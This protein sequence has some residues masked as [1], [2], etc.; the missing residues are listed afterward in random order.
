MPKNHQLPES[1]LSN[2]HAIW[3][4]IIQLLKM[5][6]P[7]FTRSVFGA[8]PPNCGFLVFNISA[9]WHSA[10]NKEFYSSN[11]Y[12]DISPAPNVQKTGW[13]GAPKFQERGLSQSGLL[14]CSGFESAEQFTER[15]QP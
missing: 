13:P 8:N 3:C 2:Y 1:S 14:I 15:G 4:N 6:Y 12:V 7:L 10:R 5:D 9:H 11:K